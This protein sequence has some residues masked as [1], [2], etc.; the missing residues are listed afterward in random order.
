MALSEVELRILSDLNTELYE[1]VLELEILVD[2]FKTDRTNMDSVGY[3][4]SYD[5]ISKILSYVTT[6]NSLKEYYSSLKD[7]KCMYD[8]YNT[9]NLI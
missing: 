8:D 2:T 7:Y 9:R 3:K 5:S 6:F 4:F 1:K